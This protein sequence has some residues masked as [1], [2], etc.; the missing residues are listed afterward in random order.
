MNLFLD[1]PDTPISNGADFKLA[2]LL[3]MRLIHSHFAARQ[4]AN[5]GRLLHPLNSAQEV[6]YDEH[7]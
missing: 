6:H 7:N 3:A 2:K 1:S 4:S 5:D